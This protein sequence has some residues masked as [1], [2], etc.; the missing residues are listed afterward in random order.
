MFNDFNVLLFNNKNNGFIRQH[1]SA[2]V[3]LVK[4]SDILIIICLFSAFLRSSYY[5]LESKQNLILLVAILVFEFFATLNNLYLIPRGVRFLFV[6]KNTITAWICSA[7]VVMAT[8]GF[9]PVFDDNQKYHIFF[10]LLTTPF[11]IIF[12]HL[13]IRL[14]LSAL[15]LNKKNIRRVAILGAT[16]LGLDLENIL[17]KQPWMGFSFTGFFDDR[18]PFSDKRLASVDV[19][20]NI[21]ELIEKAKNKEFEDIFITLPM[22]SEK[23]IKSI[24]SELRDTSVVVHFVPNLVAFDLVGGKFENFNGIPVIK[25]F[26]TPHD[27]GVDGLS[28]RLFD[29]I[30]SSSILLVIFIPMLVI[31]LMIKLSAPGPVLFIQRRYGFRGEEIN[32]WKFRSMRVCED[33]QDVTQATQNDPRITKFGQF[34]RKSSLDEL[35]QFINVLQGRMSI[36]GPRPHAVAHNEEY[37]SQISGYMLRHNVKPGITGLAQIRGFR[38]ETDTLDKMEGRIKSDLEYIHTWSI[39]LDIEIFIMTIFKGFLHENAY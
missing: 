8:I 4:T 24:L 16:T 28:K 18:A 12:W 29:L 33:G 30:I 1:K 36:V 35:P 2:L 37:R 14:A 34:L 11:V 7:F 39:W 13:I 6:I 32:V 17:I 22:Q 26:D 3:A 20:G 19:I 10:W 9:F 27:G 31:A 5:F 25:I 15:R 38:G 23:R 21:K